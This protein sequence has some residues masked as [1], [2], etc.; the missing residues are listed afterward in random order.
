MEYV[1]VQQVRVPALGFG[2][3]RMT[4]SECAQAVE[5][6]IQVGYRHIDTAEIYENE[7]SVGKGIQAAG[8]RREELFITTK[9]WMDDLS[10]SGVRKSLEGSLRRLNTDYVDLWL[11]HWPNPA[12]PLS[13]TL[14]AMMGLKEAGKTCFVGASNF[15]VALVEEAVKVAPIVCNQVEY[16]PYLSQEPILT[17]ARKHHIMVT[18]YAPIA[19]GKVGNDP[20]LVRIGERYGTS[21]AQTALRWLIQQENVSAIPKASDPIHCEENFNIFDFS[22]NDE[23]MATIFGLARG[24]R[25]INPEFAPQWD[26]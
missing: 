22:L 25:L 20:V 15:P 2:T 9:A 23:E 8:V 14:E 3:F 1:D 11:I 18:A 12:Y 4:G 13:P 5:H 10:P 19:M 26:V 21:A 7:E 24:E 17:S 6:A 16:H